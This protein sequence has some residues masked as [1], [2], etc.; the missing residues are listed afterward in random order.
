MLLMEP[1]SLPSDFSPISWQLNRFAEACQ[2]AGRSPLEACLQFALDLP[3][4]DC[5]LVGANRISELVDIL[6]S[7]R[8]QTGAPMD[9]AALAFENSRFLNPAT[10]GA[11]ALRITA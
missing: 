7:C 1:E 5:F 4:I 11:A 10:L 9:Y 2:R 3:E 6:A 8:S